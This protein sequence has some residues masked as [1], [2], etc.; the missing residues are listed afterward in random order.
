VILCIRKLRTDIGKYVFVH[1]TIELWN[2]LPAEALAA[3]TFKSHII[4][5][6]VGRVIISEEK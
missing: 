6:R 4:R 5:K 3:F 1:M 2:R